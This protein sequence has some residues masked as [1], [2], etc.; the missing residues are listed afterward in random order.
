MRT[1]KYPLSR[2]KVIV[3]LSVSYFGEFVKVNKQKDGKG[4]STWE[5]EGIAKFLTEQE[6]RKI[7]W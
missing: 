3:Y 7:S 6:K 5:I 4:M 1:W 2:L